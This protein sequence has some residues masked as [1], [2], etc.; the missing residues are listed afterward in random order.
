[1]TPR[2]AQQRADAERRRATDKL[3]RQHGHTLDKG[4]AAT[5]APAR[6]TH[7]AELPDEGE[8]ARGRAAEAERYMHMR[9][10]RSGEGPRNPKGY[11]AIAYV[12]PLG[13]LAYRQ[14]PKGHAWL[15]RH[16]QRRLP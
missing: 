4:N 1:M 2:Q 11:A 3:G 9:L 13:S 16:R 14:G 15:V 8:Q 10:T 6:T 12:A 5:D 7:S